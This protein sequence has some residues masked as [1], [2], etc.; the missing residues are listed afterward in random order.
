MVTVRRVGGGHQRSL[1]LP[2]PPPPPPL[3]HDIVPLSEVK[4]LDRKDRPIMLEFPDGASKEL[5][6][7]IDMWVAVVGWLITSGRF[8]K[9][10]CPVMTPK[11]ES[12]CLLNTE[13]RH[14]D[15]QS[16]ST[17]RKVGDIYIFTALSRY[18]VRTLSHTLIRITKLDPSAF[19][20]HFRKSLSLS[21]QK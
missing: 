12:R 18:Q 9:S 5:K 2:P 3:E 14:T 10:D 6:T 15:G 17:F 19:R 11:A 13:P 20:A 8:G 4:K 1:K 16:F 21:P 7:W